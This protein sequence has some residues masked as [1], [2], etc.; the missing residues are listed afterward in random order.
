MVR[1]LFNDAVTPSLWTSFHVCLLMDTIAGPNPPIQG[2]TPIT[3]ILAFGAAFVLTQVALRWM[4]PWLGAAI[5]VPTSTLLFWSLAPFLVDMTK[6]DMQAVV[7]FICVGLLFPATVTLLNFE[8]NRLMGPNIA[9]A[10]SGLAPVFAVLLA[11]ALLGESIHVLQFLGIT[12]IVA[13]VMFMYRERRQ[14][15]QHWSAWMLLLPLAAA[16]IRG[17][18]QPIIKLGLEQWPSPTAAVVIGYTVSSAV[19][20]STAFV[21]DPKLVRRLDRRGALWFAAV[22]LC[23]GLSVLSLYTALGRGPVALVAPL[24]ASYP[25]VTLLL[26]FVFLKHEHIGPQLVSAVAAIVGGVVL[27]II[28]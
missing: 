17:A 6:A 25:L 1:A 2:E 5:S 28:A 22:G 7:L 19:L 13:G 3:V 27:L 16:V 14:N 24:V 8:S 26:T 18:V 23:N 11:L 12:A 10:I 21:H 4:P 20:I 15:L 9:G